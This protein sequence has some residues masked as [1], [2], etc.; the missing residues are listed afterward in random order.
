[1]TADV[2]NAGE[3]YAGKEPNALPLADCL[4]NPGATCNQFACVIVERQ[5]VNQ[6]TRAES[7]VQ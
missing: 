4:F 3:E 6:I 5:R 2:P 1:M 7:P